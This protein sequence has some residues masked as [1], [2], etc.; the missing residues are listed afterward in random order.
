M[1]ASVQ[2]FFVF[3]TMIH[4]LC[5]NLIIPILIENYN[6]NSACQC[7]SCH[8]NAGMCNNAGSVIVFILLTLFFAKACSQ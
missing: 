5:T 1:T 7:E 2:N 3:C 8:Q 6:M 4:I